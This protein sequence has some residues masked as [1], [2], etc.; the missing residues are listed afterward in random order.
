MEAGLSLDSAV[1]RITEELV[2][3]YPHL[4]EHLKLLILEL[5]AGR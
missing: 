3:R 1:G 2:R 4:A 5:R